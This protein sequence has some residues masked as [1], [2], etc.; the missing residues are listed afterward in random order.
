MQYLAIEE[1]RQPNTC[2]IRKPSGRPGCV[3]PEKLLR[4]S[5]R[6]ARDSFQ[7]NA[8]LIRNLLGDET[9]MRRLAAFAPMG[10]RS[11]IGTIRFHHVTI[12]GNRYRGLANKLRILERDDS[13]E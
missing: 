11:K 1:G 12:L 7:R 4:R 8:P 13:G 10:N 3:E 9:G 6:L 2:E 5:S